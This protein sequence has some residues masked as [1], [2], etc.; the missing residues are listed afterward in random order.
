MKK[1]QRRNKTDKDGKPLDGKGEKKEKGDGEIL[2]IFIPSSVFN[3]IFRMTHFHDLD[4][5]PDI[6]FVIIQIHKPHGHHQ[7]PNAF[8]RNVKMIRI[9]VMIISIFIIDNIPNKG[10]RVGAGDGDSYCDSEA[11][12][13]DGSCYDQVPT[14]MMIIMM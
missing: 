2:I 5:H 3:M 14:M 9:F 6:L 7:L 8:V 4:D 11:S 13:D 1:M 12:M 10:E